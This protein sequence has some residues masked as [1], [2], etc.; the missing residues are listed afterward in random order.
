MIERQGSEKR[1]RYFGEDVPKLLTELV[2]TT[3]MSESAKSETY[4]TFI[5]ETKVKK[6]VILKLILKCC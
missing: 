6:I 1:S 5:R 2:A 3:E 4:H